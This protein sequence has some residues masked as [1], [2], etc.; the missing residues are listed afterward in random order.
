MFELAG[1]SLNKDVTFF[2]GFA[3]NGGSI[4]MTTMMGVQK[5]S[6]I[7]YELATKMKKYIDFENNNPGCNLMCRVI[8]LLYTSDAA[9]E[10]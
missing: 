8:C 5:L 3:Y 6:A 7:N 1:T 4:P 9:D 10:L 2:S